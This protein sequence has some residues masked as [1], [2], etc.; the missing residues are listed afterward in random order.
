[1]DRLSLKTAVVLVILLALLGVRVFLLRRPVRAPIAQTNNSETASANKAPAPKLVEGGGLPPGCT[2]H[3]KDPR[4]VSMHNLFSVRD[5]QKCHGRDEDLMNKKS[6][7]M[8]AERKA[9][10]EKRMKEEAICRECHRKGD[11][12]VTQKSQI[13]GRLFCPVDQKMLNKDAA[14]AK[15]GKYFCPKHKVELIDIDEISIKSAKEPRN[16]YCVA[17]HPINSKFGKQHKKVSATAKAIPIRDC[18]KCHS[19]HSDC[20]GCHF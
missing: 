17:C 16:E 1:M 3:S 6:E 15:E 12:I 2:C 9:G 10:L 19:S 20:G 8:T 11:I 18:L 5:C 13:S 4:F 7:V 14:V